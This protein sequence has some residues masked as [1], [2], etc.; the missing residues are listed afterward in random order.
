LSEYLGTFQPEID[1]TA[2]ELYER[3]EEKP[4]VL[5]SLRATR[6]TTDA[7]ALALALHS[8]GIGIQ[9]FVIAPATLS[10]TSLLMESALGRYVDRAADRLKR[11]QASAV[12][13]LWQAGLSRTLSALPGQLDPAIHF[14]ISPER[15]N[16]IEALLKDY[17]QPKRH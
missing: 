11:R 1:A 16:R 17:A 12:A 6:I 10:V 8:G 13:A 5:N 9:D 4:V 15:M 3:L 2:R 7:A 14:Q